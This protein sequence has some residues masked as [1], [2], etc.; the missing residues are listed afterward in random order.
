MLSRLSSL[1]VRDGLVGV[2]RMEKAF[3]R[4]VIYGGSLDTILLEMSLI[5]EDRLVQYLAL[6]SGLPPAARDEGDSI[7]PEAVALISQDLAEQYRAVPVA[8]EGDA[9]RVL[10]CAPLEIGEL[11]DLADRLD[12][13]LQPLITPEYRWNLVYSAAYGYEPPARYMQLARHLDG[14]P[15]TPAVGREKSVIIASEAGVIDTDADTLVNAESPSPATAA[16]VAAAR[17][18]AMAAEPNT[19]RLPGAARRPATENPNRGQR[20]TIVGIVPNAARTDSSPTVQLPPSGILPPRE[21]RPVPIGGRGF[22]RPLSAPLSTEGRDSPLTIAEARELLATA[23]DRDTV[24]L[25]LLRA[26]RAR[27]KWAGL[28]TIQGG[29]A[30]GR[31]AIA[32]PGLDA[33]AITTVL[34]PLDAVSPFRQVVATRRSHIG[35]LAS[36]DASVDAMVTRMG[37]AMPPSAMI[38]PI[39]LRDRTVAVVVAHRLQRDIRLVDVT[40]LL[41]MATAASDALGRLIVKHKAAGYRAPAVDAGDAGDG[42]GTTGAGELGEDN[43]ITK[44]LAAAPQAPDDPEDWSTPL[45]Q[46]PTPVPLPAAPNDQVPTAPIAQLADGAEPAAAPPID[47]LL[48]AVES[49]KEG[50]PEA[51]H[52]MA[53]VVERALE[54]IEPISKRF[55]G[56]LR[57]DRFAVSGRALRPAQ[58]GGLLEL[59]IRLGGVAGD[60]IVEKLDEPQRDIRFYAAVCAIEL[61]PRNA[62]FVLAERLF[63]QDYG[64]R[65]CALEAL[66]GYPPQ[67]LEHAYTRARSAISSADPEMVGASASAVVAL[68]DVGAIEELIGAIERGGRIGEHVRRALVSLTAHDFGP[69]ERKWRKWWDSGRRRHRIEWLIEGLSHKEDAIRE[70][71]IHDLR[72][73][74][75]EY[76][77]YHHDLPRREREAAADRWAAWWRETGRRRFTGQESERHRITAKLKPI[78][79][80]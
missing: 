70:A 9:V 50:S 33:K 53:E 32:E 37:G 11:E 79:E 7:E 55:P 39:V 21:N 80:E 45:A 30:I 19:L 20:H 60:L 59:V 27:A 65:A 61:R 49:S 74:T 38:L 76:F 15:S 72:R 62:V 5:P 47:D 44:R 69:S 56:K 40:E 71:A 73:L 36:K 10:V 26:V 78:R 43:A 46:P 6:A 64:V 75:G 34:I 25:T 29:A 8:I 42:G 35:P 31:L 63:D 12:R 66:A 16:A 51:E 2:K 67:D 23:E 54:A 13:A 58:Y 3:Q 24:F 18:P 57:V 4:Q 28:L 17:L 68:G 14:D 48:W 77:G 52:A 22:V 41:P 1:L